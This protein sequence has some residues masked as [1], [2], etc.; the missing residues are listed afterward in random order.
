LCADIPPFREIGGEDVEYFSLDESP[1]AIAERIMA[2]EST[3]KPHRMH[4]RVVKNYV[5]DTIY[6]RTLRPFLEEVLRQRR[7]A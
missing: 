2:M 7:G 3:L 6:H 1:E 5:W 4:R